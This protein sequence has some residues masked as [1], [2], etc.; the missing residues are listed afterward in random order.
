MVLEN[1]I[2]SVLKTSVPQCFITVIVINM[3]IIHFTSLNV[4][5]GVVPVRKD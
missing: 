1:S 4:S 5:K 2:S 3:A